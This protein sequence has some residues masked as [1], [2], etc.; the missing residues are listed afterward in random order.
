M[1]DFSLQHVREGVVLLVSLILSIAVHEFGHAFSADRLGD[2]LPRSQ[3]RVTLNPFVHADPIGTLA[4]PLI[5]HFVFGGMLF[6]WGRPV[7]VNPVAFN[8]RLR[9]KTAHA[10]VAFAGPLMNVLLAVL[11]TL[12]LT[13]L[14]ATGIVTPESEL[15]RGIVMVIQLN[16]V[17][18]FFNLI[19]T[20]PL[21]G[22]AVLAWMLP[23]RHERVM[24]TLQQ[25]GF[26]IL[27]L[28]LV[29]GVLG[30]YF[31]FTALPMTELFL[32]FAWA[33]AY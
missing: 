1:F 19:P 18:F 22:G 2:R 11:V 10:I 21:D 7:M 27:L 31:R 20:P 16:W 28:L 8:R 9:M 14:W 17:L 12:L 5:G 30:P 3:G 4:F 29:S 15:S 6:G 33:V 25:Y 13:V 26:V 23:D 32:G 24:D